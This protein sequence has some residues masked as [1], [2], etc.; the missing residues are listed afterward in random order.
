MRKLIFIGLLL[1]TSLGT[2]AQTQYAHINMG[3]LISD[4]PAAQAANA[5][6]EVFQKELIAKGEAMAAAFQEEYVAFA[7][8]VQGG[9]LP[10][11]K[12]Q[13]QQAVLEQKQQD[14]MAYEQQ[15][16]VD[17]NKK[18]DELL[19]PIIEKAQKAIADVARENNIQLVFDTSI[20]GAIM[21]AA[22]SEDL[23]PKVKAKLNIVD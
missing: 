20:F 19:Q 10:P 1:L 13:E 23:M 21:F 17:I 3:N 4:M 16:G 2:Q 12:Q 8:A 7:K 18:R 15:I 22:E 11:V 5:E 14:I 9:T 6:L